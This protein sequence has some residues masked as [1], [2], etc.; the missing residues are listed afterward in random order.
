MTICLWPLLATVLLQIM[1]AFLTRALPTLAPILTMQA[2]VSATA[3]GH[4]SALN[5]IGSVVFLIMGA[6]LI[7]RLGP[8]RTLQLGVACSGIGGVLVAAPAAPGARNGAF[9]PARG[10]GCSS[11]PR[12]RPWG[13][14]SRAC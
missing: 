8:V 4:Y 13:S 1:S 10:S 7:R 2:G 3:V 6:P 14:P 12:R 9:T 5:T 11:S